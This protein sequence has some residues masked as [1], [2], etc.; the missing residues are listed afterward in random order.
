[1]FIE[2]DYLNTYHIFLTGALM[3]VDVIGL[4]NNMK[5]SLQSKKKSTVLPTVSLLSHKAISKALHIHH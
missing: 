2:W 4:Y 5:Y 1:M 3:N